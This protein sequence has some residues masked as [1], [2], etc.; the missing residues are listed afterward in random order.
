MAEM[1]YEKK[2][3][4]KINLGLDVL[5]RREDGY[6]ELRMIMQTVG[7]YDTVT[8]EKTDKRWEITLR[9][10]NHLLPTDEHNLMVKA[11]KKMWECYDLPGGLSMT[12]K[13]KI[14]M[15]AGLAGG[16]SD[17]ACVIKGISEIYGLG[18][19]TEE[20]CKTGVTIGA[21]VP[22]CIVG[23]T[24]LAEGIGEKLTLIGESLAG[25][26]TVIIKPDFDVSTKYV[27]EN[28]HAD[29]LSYHP[30]IDAQMKAVGEGDLKGC[31]SLMG[32]VLERVSVT[33]YPEIDEI[34][35]ELK[36]LGAMGAMMSGSGPSVFGIFAD[37]I[38]AEKAA[39]KLAE[40]RKTAA[41]FAT[42]WISREDI[43]KG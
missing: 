14:P 13:K 19:S 1:I 39:A 43:A 4:A 42:E 20:L 7:I 12:L 8:F 2:A 16:S 25:T 18:L 9:T 32:N 33:K 27:Y 23:G 30:D 40:R 11:A 26:A 3:Y 6:H 38:T 35:E 34:K 5:R 24:C 31:V 37:R 17:A 10:D 21:D 28:L 36:Q 22:Y 15:A 41:V 29:T